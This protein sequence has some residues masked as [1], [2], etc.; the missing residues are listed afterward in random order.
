M[1]KAQIIAILSILAL[2]GGFVLVTDI[3]RAGRVKAAVEGAYQ[4]LSQDETAVELVFVS[5]ADMT[6]ANQSLFSYSQS[7]AADNQAQCNA[8]KTQMIDAAKNKNRQAFRSAAQQWISLK[9]FR[10]I[11]RQETRST[12]G[13]GSTG[14]GGTAAAPACNMTWDAPRLSDNKGLRKI[15]Q[16]SNVNVRL[17]GFSANARVRLQN[18]GPT[19]VQGSLVRLSSSGSYNYYDSTQI[20]DSEYDPG[21][22]NTY[23]LDQ[24]NKP[25]TTCDIGFKI[26]PAVN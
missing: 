24:A 20:K 26:E 6:Q 11:Q 3:Q 23:V 10:N 4:T 7:R 21:F 15:G 12:S 22:Y 9:C 18:N 1:N 2:V 14:R 17:S 19:T 25:L 13:P 16:Y 8:L 5:F